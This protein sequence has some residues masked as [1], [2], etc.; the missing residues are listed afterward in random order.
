MGWDV[1]YYVTM[2]SV[3]MVLAL[4]ANTSVPGF[5]TRRRVLAADRYLPPELAP[6][7]SRLVFTHGVVV[8]AVLAGLLGAEDA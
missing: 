7:G 6:R 1:F 3:L 8:L 5:P 2:T 4:P